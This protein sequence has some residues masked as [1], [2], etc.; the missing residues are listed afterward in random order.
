MQAWYSQ[1]KILKD[2]KQCLVQLFSHSLEHW[3][4]PLFDAFE[5]LEMK[6]IISYKKFI[7]SFYQI[8]NL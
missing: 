5:R 7:F 1:Q 8:Y 4:L 2:Q 6:S 3:T